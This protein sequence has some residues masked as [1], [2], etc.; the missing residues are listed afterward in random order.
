M[1]IAAIPL[2][3]P[4]CPLPV[5]ISE[6]VRETHDTY[7]LTTT[8]ANGSGLPPFLPGQFS[9]VFEFGV[10]EVPISIS[11]DAEIP[12]QLVF[13]IRSVGAVT[14]ALVGHKPGDY[15][16][17]RGSFGTAW[18]LEA[19]RGQDV[20]LVAGGIGLAPLRPVIS[21]V[22]RHRSDFGRFLL[23][24]GARTP[25]DLLFRKQLHAWSALPESQ[26]LVTVDCADSRWRGHVGIVTKLFD[27]V[28]LR[29]E[30]TIAMTCG[31]EIMMRF[32]IRALRARKL[33]AGQIYLSMERNMECG[34]G[35]C[36]HCQMGPLF[37]CKDGPIFAYLQVERW[38]EGHHEL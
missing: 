10:G 3:D 7:T 34:I 28:N 27:F 24:Y 5:R 8:A 26:V 4:M 2:P 15:L 35:F 14:A 21:H 32:V 1:S 20:L 22:A 33:E 29:P 18:P 31:P 23:L 16:G 11:G 13:T 17:V 25:K 37:L 6:V 12:G 38:L 9:M 30:R 36:G 19:A